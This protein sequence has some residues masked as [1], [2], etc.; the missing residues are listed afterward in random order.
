MFQVS[1]IK[2]KEPKEYIEFSKRIYLSDKSTLQRL[3]GPLIAFSALFISFMLNYWSKTI[4]PDFNGPNIFYATV[5]IF[6]WSAFLTLFLFF[7]D[8]YG[9][10]LGLPEIKI[11]DNRILKSHLSNSFYKYKDIA[12]FSFNE[13]SYELFSCYELVLELKKKSK[14]VKIGMNDEDL[15]NKVFI[16]LEGQGLTFKN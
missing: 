2:W 12:S 3:K 7:V 8:R 14:T 15:K 10:N 1:Y 13:F 5:F 4:R 16:I 6:L 11:Q 9:H